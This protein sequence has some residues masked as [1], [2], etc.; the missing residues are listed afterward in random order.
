MTSRRAQSYGRVME[1]LRSVGESKLH[2]EE[3]DQI[4]EA[5]DALLF[6]EDIDTGPEAK[7]ALDGVRDLTRRLVGT[8][9]WTP[10][11]ADRLLEDVAGC[12]PVLLLV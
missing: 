2:A 12:G 7:V 9:R 11:T 8:G 10:D 6:C 5:A 1:T 3:Q 4:R